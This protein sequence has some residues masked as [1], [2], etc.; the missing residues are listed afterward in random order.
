MSYQD[1]VPY[2]REELLEK[3]AAQMSKKKIQTCFGS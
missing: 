3:I 1:Y 2:T